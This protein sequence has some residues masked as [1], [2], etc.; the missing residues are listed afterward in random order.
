MILQ[1]LSRYL[2]F[3]NGRLKFLRGIRYD[4]LPPLTHLIIGFLLSGNGGSGSNG[5]LRDIP[6]SSGSCSCLHGFITA[7]AILV[8]G[9]E[10][11]M[12]AYLRT[13]T[14]LPFLFG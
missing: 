2:G 6:S 10:L 9:S 14:N 1:T 7:T 3:L 5:D 11:Q 4:P 12:L 13:I 8:N